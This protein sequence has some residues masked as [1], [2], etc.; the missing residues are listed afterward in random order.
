[1]YWNKVK[2]GRKPKGLRVGGMAI[3]PKG[4]LHLWS[5]YSGWA[6]CGLESALLQRLDAPWTSYASRP[7]PL[8]RG[9]KN[10][11]ALHLKAYKVRSIA[12]LVAHD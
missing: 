5:S 6:F 7:E 1:M 9:C 2:L 3:G 12:E 11:L 4:T 8:C 10:N